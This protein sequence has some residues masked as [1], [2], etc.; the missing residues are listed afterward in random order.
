MQL[1]ECKL[2]LSATDLAKH[3][4]CRHATSPDLK[5]SRGEINQV[6]RRDSSL[7]LLEERGRR[8]EAAYLAY[9]RDQGYDVLAESGGLDRTREAM[10]SGVGVIAQADLQNGRWRGFSARPKQCP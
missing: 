8:H 9:L 10:I 6:Y 5:A 1:I 3:L 7:E 2:L 4:A